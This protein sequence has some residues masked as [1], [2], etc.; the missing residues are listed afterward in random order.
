MVHPP[1]PLWS[2]T[3]RSSHRAREVE[4]APF[5]AGSAGSP[6]RAYAV[7]LRQFTAWCSRHDHHLCESRSVDIDC[8]FRV[9]P[10]PR[11]SRPNDGT[12]PRP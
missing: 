3:S 8:P 6:P 12:E 9:C 11:R 5:V 2:G 7:D 1:R 4:P 10:S